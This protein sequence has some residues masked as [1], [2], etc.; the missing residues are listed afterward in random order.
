MKGTI[1]NKDIFNSSNAT[2]IKDAGKEGLKCK[3]FGYGEKE[4]EQLD[5]ETGEVIQQKV[6]VIKTDKG[7]IAGA[8]EVIARRL[9]ELSEFVTDEELV[10]GIDIEFVEIK[11]GRGT[12]VSFNLL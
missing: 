10:E 12:A 1:T 9:N 11:A 8:S 3:L 4:V 5:K 6:S 7:P 2:S